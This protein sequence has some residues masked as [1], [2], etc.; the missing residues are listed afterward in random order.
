MQPSVVNSAMQSS[1]SAGQTKF[2]PGSK[3]PS[4]LRWRSLS[5]R[6]K[7]ILLAVA[8]STLPVF[9]VGTTAFLVQS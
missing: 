7:G 9:I 2:Y 3:R 6:V 8:M 1:T 5:L 4:S